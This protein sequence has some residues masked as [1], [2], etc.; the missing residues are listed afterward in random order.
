[1]YDYVDKVHIITYK[2]EYGNVR[3]REKEKLQCSITCC[4]QVSR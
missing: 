3:Q 4:F 1:M 2:Y